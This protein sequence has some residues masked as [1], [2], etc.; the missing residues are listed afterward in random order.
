MGRAGGLTV[1]TRLIVLGATLSV[2]IAVELIEQIQQKTQRAVQV[3]EVG[4]E[5]TKGGVTTADRGS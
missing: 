5:R 2:L 3:V 4:A 1:R